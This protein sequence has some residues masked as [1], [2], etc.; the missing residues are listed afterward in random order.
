MGTRC[1]SF[2]EPEPNRVLLR[3]AVS[4][5]L[6]AGCS[7]GPELLP[8]A[9]VVALDGKP[10]ADAGVL[11]QPVDG[12]PIAGATTDG[13]GKF[14]LT[15]MNRPGAMAG[16]YRVTITKKETTG[17]GKLGIIGPHGVQIK[18]IVPKKYS[19]PES[20]NL[21]ASVSRDQHE[22]SFTLSSQ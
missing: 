7:R 5:T 14:Q 8:V 18:W 22:F 9:G 11:F 21:H 3:I 17:V 20:S 12:G 4:L 15:S 1:R 13:N 2:S 19:K 10:V 6:L 16:P